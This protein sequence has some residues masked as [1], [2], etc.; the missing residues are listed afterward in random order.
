MAALRGEGLAGEAMP[1]DAPVAAIYAY[2]ARTPCKLLMVQFEDLLDRHTPINLPGTTDEYP[3][4]RQRMPCSTEQAL[5]TPRMQEI[6]ARLNA[7]GRANPADEG[8]R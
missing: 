8:P 2:L 5:A 6:A 7:E 4:W 3:N 1:G